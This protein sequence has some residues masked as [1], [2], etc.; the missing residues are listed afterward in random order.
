[1]LLQDQVSHEKICIQKYTNYANQTQDP[2]LKQLFQT[3]A[4]EEQEHLNTLDQILAG[5]VPNLQQQQAQQQQAEQQAQQQMQQPAGQQSAVQA[6]TGGQAGMDR[7]QDKDLC[8]DLLMTEKYMSDT[9]DTAI[10]EFT[11]SNVRQV[12]NHIQKEEQQHGEGIFNYM[13]SHG[14]Y[15]PQ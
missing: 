6:A 3:Y 14:M 8:S 12:L 1:M 11:D 5:T 15:N 9:Y 4:Q 2:Q 10:F 13:Q 7:Q